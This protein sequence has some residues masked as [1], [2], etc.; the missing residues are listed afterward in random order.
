[1]KEIYLKC[2][3]KRNL[4]DDMF[5]D[6]LCSRYPKVIFK[7]LNYKNGKITPKIKNL[8][9]I[10]VNFQIY[11]LFR[12]IATKFDTRNF[13]E[14]ILVKK[15]KS[16][17]C[18]GGS[19]FMEPKDYLKDEKADSISWY[20]NINVPYFIIG[21]NIGPIYTKKYL[22]NVKEKV[23]KN[24][25]DVCFRDEKSYEY[26][27]ELSNVRHAPDIVFGY[28]C[29]KY[30]TKNKVK[31][32]IISVIN[33]RKKSSQIVNPNL[34][35]YEK[36]INNLI[37]YF[38]NR[39]YIVELMSFCR[40]EGD[41]EAIE[42]IISKNKNNNVIK[43]YF[44]NGNIEE[45][46]TELSTAETIVAT[47]F[48]ANIIGLLLGKNV[49]PIIYNDKTRN[50][51]KDINFEGKYIDLDSIEQFYI[52]DLREEDLKYK[53]DVAEQIKKSDEQFRELDKIILDRGM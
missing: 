20:K 27:K 39:N 7:T 29:E 18:I 28:D 12:K 35:E 26:V 53:I 45:A 38:I 19:V 22:D 42:M 1:M 9:T 16:I 14:T 49:I 17:I 52:E 33:L 41:E 37:D 51:L 3:Y 4:G 11:R 30:K 2:V 32:V 10:N 48:H 25:K 8:K 5:V 13:L 36:T 24:A 50:L 31:K 21:A 40:E 47:R 15:A 46:I 34:E 44:Y 6:M 23:L 43:K